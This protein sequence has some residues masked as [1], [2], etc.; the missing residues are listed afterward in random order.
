[1]E[2]MALRLPRMKLSCGSSQKNWLLTQAMP[3]S[4]SMESTDIDF[5]FF[6]FYFF[7]SHISFGNLGP[8]SGGVESYS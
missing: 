7:G 6:I 2:V 8:L 3:R 1:M 4:G 5:L